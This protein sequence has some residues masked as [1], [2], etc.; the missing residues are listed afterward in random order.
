MKSL[1]QVLADR[2]GDAAVLRRS[3][4]VHEADLIER[5]CED[6]AEVA[7]EYV[8]WLTEGEAQLRSRRS[9][10]WLRARFPEWERAGHARREGRTRL[11]RMLIVP[12]R[13]DTAA[14]REAGRRAGRQAA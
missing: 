13:A 10:P 8:T 9:P 5:I 12:R 2:R 6:V 3:G 1:E 11:Y 4:H 7:H 14:A